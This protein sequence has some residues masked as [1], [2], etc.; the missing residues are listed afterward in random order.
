VKYKRDEKTGYYKPAVDQKEGKAK[1]WNIA[2]LSSRENPLVVFTLA[3]QAAAGAFG[4]LTLGKWLGVASLVAVAQSPIAALIVFA[5]LCLIALG[6]LMS[7]I[8]LG[9]PMRF[10]RGF[11]NLR[12]SPV[13]REGLG[14]VLFLTFAGI[15]WLA[16]LPTNAWVQML[17]GEVPVALLSASSTVAD[18][19]AGL[20]LVS[21]S[22]A[23]YYM[24]RCYRI[25]ARPFWNH[26]Q[27]AFAFAGTVLNLGSVVVGVFAVPYLLLTGASATPLLSLLG[28]VMAAGM[29]LEAVGLYLHAHDLE[30]AEHEGAVS[31]YIQLT[32][33]GKTYIA[34]NSMMALNTVAV[35]LLA[36]FA[37]DDAVSLAAWVLVLISAIIT[38]LVGRALFYVLVVP[39][40]MPGAF[41][42]KN[43]AFEQHARDIGLADMPQ[44]GVVPLKH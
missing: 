43:K 27:T 18:V 36:F 4:L 38:S 2:R 1:S 30:E 33:F 25:K 37:G 34:R 17:V 14:I 12:H 39:T 29:A 5:S 42:W 20:A 26:K 31:F 3:A 15:S 28:I 7:T 6:L 21:A 44:V 8:H 9:K 24:Y 23:L 11:N 10:Y 40:T 32:T 19:T 35:L 22:V 13:S 16:G 41:F